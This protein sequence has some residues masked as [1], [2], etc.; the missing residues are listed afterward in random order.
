VVDP[1]AVPDELTRI[2]REPDKT[3]INEAYAQ[4]DALPNWLVRIDPVDVVTARKK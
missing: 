4:S 1:D 3:A 2:K